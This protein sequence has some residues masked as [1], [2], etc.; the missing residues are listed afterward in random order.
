MG[1]RHGPDIVQRWEGNPAIT[2]RDLSFRC[3]DICNAAAVKLADEYIL[4]LSIQS[5]EGFHH[6]YR[7][8]SQDGFHFEVE[9]EPCMGRAKEGPFA[10]YEEQGILDARITLLEDTYYITY[11][12]LSHHG[13]R[14]AL[15]KTKDFHTIER[16]GLMS[17][18]DTK[19][20]VLFPERFN[21]R[22]A[23]LERPWDGGSIWVSFS[24]DLTYWGGSEVVLTPRGGF[25]DQDRVGVATPPIRIEMGWLFIYYG[26]KE[27][28]AGPLFR[29]GAA[30]LDPDHP[31]TVIR[32]TNVPI[33]VPR[34]EE[35]RIGDVPNLVFSCGAILEPN[36]EFRIYYGASNSCICIGTTNIEAII[37]ACL[38]SEK[39]Y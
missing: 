33:L 13:Y 17:E 12:A 25:W 18:P 19:A 29:L 8:H 39:E 32:R 5:Q 15:A 20:G 37:E 23:R 34:T 28:S 2:I 1:K 4:L 35:E 14:L 6:L 36:N 7:A 10:L 9:D 38:D 31:E 26:V 27:T 21:G 3:S 24:D 30:I 16:V 11:D 22:Y